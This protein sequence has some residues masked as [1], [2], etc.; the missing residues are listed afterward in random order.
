MK[1]YARHDEIDPQNKLTISSPLNQFALCSALLPYMDTIWHLKHEAN[2]NVADRVDVG[3]EVAK[4]LVG[5]FARHHTDTA[6][7][8]P[9]LLMW[10]ILG[11][12]EYD[13]TQLPAYSAGDNAVVM[14]PP[15]P[16]VAVFESE[17]E[18]T[19]LF[20]ACDDY[21]TDATQHIEGGGHLGNLLLDHVVLPLRSI[22]CELATAHGVEVS[23]EYKTAWGM[24]PEHELNDSDYE[25]L[26]Q[27]ESGQPPQ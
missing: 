11:M 3:Y 23:D 10:T 13:P 19:L 2:L 1:E 6:F 16:D 18:I 26:A 4:K 22:I 25:F 20:D 24:P 27:I 5:G 12:K 7:Q 21:L 17:E 14:G 8:P 15:F 9:N